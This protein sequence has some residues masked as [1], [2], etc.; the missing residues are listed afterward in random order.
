MRAQDDAE[1]GAIEAIYDALERGDPATA[2]ELARR[3]RRGD[4]T[5]LDPVL[6]Y[7]A[8][9]ALLELDRP[10]AAAESLALATS[11]DGD[12]PEFLAY[13]AWALFRG[14]RFPEARAEL[15]RCLALDER[16]AEAHYVAGL[17]YE[18][19]GELRRADTSFARA[20]QLAP[21]WFEA[22]RRFTREEFGRQLELARR[23]LREEFR[24]HLDQITLIVDDLPSDALIF[25][26]EPPLD[27][28]LTLGL[29][30][31]LSLDQQ[32]T[33]GTG[34]ELPPR[35]YLFKR[36]HERST[37]AAEELS[38]QIRVTLFHELGHYLGMDEAQLEESGYA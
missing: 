19:D 34:G 33:Q 14:A 29:F 38:E 3:E 5:E 35:I 15:Q 24:R 7:L 10:A 26:E 6:C 23:G 11:L 8:G 1:L 17:V 36:N 4:G 20:A 13:H 12:D 9:R 25:E 22:P 16:L 32:S 21:D 30:A 28:E 18:R 37:T 27:P 31:G 2:L